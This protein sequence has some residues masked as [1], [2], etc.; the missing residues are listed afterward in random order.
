MI[1]EGT[2]TIIYE[3]P[4][5]A[6][7]GMKSTL[8]AGKGS[9]GTATD[10]SSGMDTMSAREMAAHD[11][12]VTR[13]FPAQTEGVGGRKLKPRVV[14]GVKVCELT[15]DEVKWGGFP[16]RVQGGMGLQRDGPGPQISVELGDRVRIV[17]HNK[18]AEPTTIH[19]HGMT[20]PADMDGVPVIS[21]DPVLP[22]SR[23]LRVH[24]SEHGFQHVPLA[25]QRPEAGSHGPLGSN[26]HSRRP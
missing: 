7:G 1:A 18:L 16:R 17:L 12:E 4:G 10:H 24:R 22:E 11:A 20:V 3:V 25:L 14:G 13:S 15:A 19:F 23:S 8:T 26:D 2:Y 21:Q 5:H 6:D 9:A